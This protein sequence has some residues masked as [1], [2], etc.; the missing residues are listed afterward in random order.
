MSNTYSLFGNTVSSTFQYLVQVR[1]GNEYYD[2]FGNPLNI[3]AGIQGNTGPQGNTGSQGETGPQG[4]TGNQGVTGPQ[5]FTG[6]Q[7]ETGSQGAVVTMVQTIVQWTYGGLTSSGVSSSNFYSTENSFSDN[8]EFDFSFFDIN[9]VDYS[10]WFG[11]LNT[12]VLN[13]NIS[14]LQIYDS[15]TSS[16]R[17]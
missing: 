14:Y 5:G 8:T 3:G 9:N 10:D 12:F 11:Q 15:I 4:F 13:N 17:S 1:S 16:N 7:G 6:V 2:G